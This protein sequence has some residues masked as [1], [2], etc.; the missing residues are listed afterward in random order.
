MK[1]GFIILLIIICL[2]FSGK[3]QRNSPTLISPTKPWTI[4]WWMGNAVDK[5]NIR[6]SLQ[7]FAE[8]GLGGV[9][10][11][12]IYG[13]KGEESKFIPYLSDKWQKMLAYTAIEA[14]KLGLGVDM[15]LGTGWCFG[16]KGVDQTNGLM[17]S[18]YTKHEING[19]NIDLDLTIKSKFQYT[20][21]QSVLAIASDSSRILLNDFL[22]ADNHLRWYAPSGKTAIYISAIQGPIFNVKRSAPDDEGF[23]LDPFSPEAFK[24]YATRFDTAFNGNLKHCIRAIYHDS[25][26][27]YGADWTHNFFDEF[28]KRRGYDL[29]LYTPELNGEGDSTTVRCIVADY[30]QTLAEL[31]REYINEIARWATA[32][33]LNFRNQAHGSPANWLDVYAAAGIPETEVFGASVFNIPGIARDTQFIAPDI[34]NVFINKFASSA[35]HVSGKN[36]ISSETHTWLREHFQV[37]LSHCKPELDRLFLAGINHIFYHGIAY[38]PQDAEWPGWLFYAETNFAPANSIFQH[39]SALNQYVQR[40]QTVLQAGSHDNEVLVYFPI[41]D[42]WQLPKQNKDKLYQLTIHDYPLWLK[43][44]GFYTAI[45][46]LD[47]LGFQFDYISDEQLLNCKFNNNLINTMGGQYK[48]LVV[49]YCKFMPVS[50]LNKIA[51]LVKNGSRVIFINTLPDNAPGFISYNDPQKIFDKMKKSMQHLPS[52]NIRIIHQKST[53][54]LINQ[55]KKWAVKQELFQRYQINFIRRK[56]CDTTYYFIANLHRG[57]NLNESI[58]L[59]TQATTV[60]ITNPLTGAS[61]KAITTIMA[62]ATTVLL[63]MKP[64]ESLILKT[65]TQKNI[66]PP[67]WKYQQKLYEPINISGN[68]TVEFLD[69]GPTLPPKYTTTTLESWTKQTDSAYSHF[70][71]KVRY[72]TEMELPLLT[73]DDY[74]LTFEKVKESASIKINGESVQVLVAFPFEVPVGK[75]LRKGKN[76]I[77]IEV[78]NLAANRIRYLDIIKKDW[79][80]FYDINYVNI[81]YKPFNASGWQIEDAGIIGKIQLIPFDYRH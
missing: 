80:K 19:G 2:S 22:G 9:H 77:E 55:L 56:N 1:F 74:L 25:Y 15:T 34:P 49:P 3:Y 44:T 37:A 10:I 40:C 42:I 12:P 50:T 36:L 48:A 47:S 16:G 38:S 26:E 32:N 45:N 43:P 57:T 58:M 7:T 24:K 13:V 8:A 75:Y 17:K 63:Q 81:K 76:L 14:E 4:W 62:N 78:V 30:R 18:S 31:H 20:K 52:D 46:L 70:A 59:G 67:S 65:T 39:F 6:Y 35:A 72:T 71:G 61:G 64:G 33:H 41:Y 27:Y 28:N 54:E 69:G 11:V 29:R 66:L 51:D 21:I 73:A 68:W 53:L 79:R 5:G 23:M 60:T